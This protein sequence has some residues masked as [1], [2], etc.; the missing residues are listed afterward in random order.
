MRST[1]VL[2]L[3]LNRPLC[4]TTFL[5]EPDWCAAKLAEAVYDL[6]NPAGAVAV[7]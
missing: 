1:V 6:G 5:I 2:L 4:T 7:S 3:G